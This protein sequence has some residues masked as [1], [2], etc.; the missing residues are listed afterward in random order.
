MRCVAVA[1]P[2]S[3]KRNR[4]SLLRR[5]KRLASG[6]GTPCLLNLIHVTARSP[7]LADL[8]DVDVVQPAVR[9][10]ATHTAPEVQCPGAE[11]DTRSPCGA[12]IG[13][14]I[15]DQEGPGDV[16][17]VVDG[18]VVLDTPVQLDTPV[19]ADAVNNDHPRT[20]L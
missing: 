1:S 15:L 13:G 17:A 18:D 2:D 9:V 10:V 20:R 14:E 6:I 7:P 8:G 19:R 12:T 5:S 16:L 11:T 3:S 4:S